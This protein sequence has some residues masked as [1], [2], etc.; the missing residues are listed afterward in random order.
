MNTSASNGSSPPTPSVL[1]SP[2]LSSA[3][4]DLFSSSRFTLRSPY[5]YSYE[6]PFILVKQDAYFYS[7]PSSYRCSC[8]SAVYQSASPWL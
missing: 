8:P 4:P 5:D 7:F 1:S 6:H 3:L 2:S